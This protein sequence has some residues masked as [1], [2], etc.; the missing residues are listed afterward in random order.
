MSIGDIVLRIKTKQNKKISS[1]LYLS[2]E[3][4]SEISF[5]TVFFA[6][7]FKT[8]DYALLHSVWHILAMK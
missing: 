3:K 1:R 7:I 6:K 8:W 4:K 2:S 5:F